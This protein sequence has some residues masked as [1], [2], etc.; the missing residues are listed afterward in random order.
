MLTRMSAFSGPERIPFA[1]LLSFLALHLILWATARFTYHVAGGQILIRR[2][3]LGR[4]PAGTWVISLD[5]VAGARR[6][7]LWI[8]LTA[9]ILGNPYSLH[10]V[11]VTA[12]RGRPFYLTPMNPD[13]FIREINLAVRA[14]SEAPR[15]TVL[16]RRCRAPV[17]LTDLVAL[18]AAI[19]F[20][21]ALA[22]HDYSGALVII[23]AVVHSWDATASHGGYLMETLPA[24]PLLLLAW[25]I[26]DAFVEMRRTA[27][28]RFAIWI[29]LMFALFPVTWLYYLVERRPWCARDLSSQR[30]A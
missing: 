29:V 18:A 27:Q 2:Y 16:R 1:I 15:P 11:V 25:M 14:K 30:G 8:P 7:V 3:I 10:G 5:A 9:R 13:E 23:G 19:P 17:W 28:P 12:R 6:S 24:L 21:V 20:T 26:A 4:V 22:R